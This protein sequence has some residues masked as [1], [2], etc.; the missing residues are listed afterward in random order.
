[1]KLLFRT[2]FKSFVKIFRIKLKG[3]AMEKKS[4]YIIKNIPPDFWKKVKIYA[5]RNGTTIKNLIISLL[6]D[7]ISKNGNEK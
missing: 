3:S 2:H 7:K 1:M 6:A 4:N 5:A